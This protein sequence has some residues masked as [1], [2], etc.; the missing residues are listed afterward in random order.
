MIAIILEKHDVDLKHL[1]ICVNSQ[2]CMNKFSKIVFDFIK[3]SNDVESEVNNK[4]ELY[5]LT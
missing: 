4:K 3:Q 2:D 1:E 5:N